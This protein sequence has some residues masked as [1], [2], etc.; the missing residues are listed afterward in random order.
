MCQCAA[1]F[2]KIMT[3]SIMAVSIMTVSIMSVSIMSVS[4]MAVSIMTVSIMTV[5]I[6]IETIAAT[7]S[8]T[9]DLYFVPA[10]SG[11]FAPYWQHDA[12]GFVGQFVYYYYYY[13]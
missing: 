10:F 3:V 6:L 12:R 8:N 5:S 7:V 13:Y 4:I 11:M 2:A 9:G 1:S